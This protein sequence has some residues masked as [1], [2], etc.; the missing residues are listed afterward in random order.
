MDKLKEFLQWNIDNPRNVSFKNIV[1]YEDREDT[2]KS[3]IR[4]IYML[5]RKFPI[6]GGG[7]D[8]PWI[9]VELHDKQVRANHGQS[10]ERIA[11]RG[12]LG[13]GEALAVLEDRKYKYIDEDA[14]RIQVL[15]I[16]ADFYRLN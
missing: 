1:G 4:M 10:L 6:L 15:E 9:I 3:M 16:V 13:W 7:M 12:G 11:E 2:L 14:A 8:I 5:E